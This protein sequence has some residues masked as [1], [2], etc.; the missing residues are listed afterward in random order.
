MPVSIIDYSKRET[1]VIALQGVH[2]V[3]SVAFAFDPASF[4]SSQI[5]LLQAAKEAGVKRFAPSDWAYAEAA[6]DFIGVYHPKAEIWEAVKE[7][8]LQYTAFRPGLFL[9]FTAFGSTK[10]ERDERVF[11]ASPEFPIGLNIAAGRAD[12]PGSGEE[13]L[14]ITFTDDIA[15]FAAASLDTEWKTESGMAGTVTTLN[16]LVNIAEKV[17]GKKNSSSRDVTFR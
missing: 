16:E 3:I 5:T 8:G 10:L 13:R 6:N 9:N 11:K 12:V 15:G 2:T 17:T 4:V 14:N 1:L 7:S